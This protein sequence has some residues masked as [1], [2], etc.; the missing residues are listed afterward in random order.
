MLGWR[1][2]EAYTCFVIRMIG[3]A[4]RPSPMV[5][6]KSQQGCIQ[7]DNVAVSS[8]HVIFDFHAGKFFPDKPARAC[9]AVKELPLGAKVEIEAV[10][11]T[12]QPGSRL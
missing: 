6:G 5:G 4:F 7:R 2:V 10:A 8:A 12:D 1:E 9:Y 3:R 11:V